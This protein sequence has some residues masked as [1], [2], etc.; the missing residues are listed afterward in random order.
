MKTLSKIFPG[1]NDSLEKYLVAYRMIYLEKMHIRLLIYAHI[2][3]YWK[4][5]HKLIPLHV[6]FSCGTFSPILSFFGYPSFCAPKNFQS[7]LCQKFKMI[8]SFHFEFNSIFKFVDVY[9]WIGDYHCFI[10]NLLLIY[11]AFWRYSLK[12]VLNIWYRI[13]F[14]RYFKI[15]ISC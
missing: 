13:R 3:Y 15:F 9:I 2:D 7:F 10:I 12:I 11:H 1:K 8:S 6:I 4:Y 5:Y 14:I